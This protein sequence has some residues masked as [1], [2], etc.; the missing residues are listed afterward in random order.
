MPR[1]GG[2]SD[3]TFRPSLLRRG[4]VISSNVGEAESRK[5]QGGFGG[6]SVTILP[7]LVTSKPLP[8][9]QV[10]CEPR[11]VATNF[12]QG[13]AQGPP[14]SVLDLAT[15]CCTCHQHWLLSTVKCTNNR[16]ANGVPTA[17]LEC[18][19]TLTQVH[20]SETYL[21]VSESY[22]QYNQTSYQDEFFYYFLQLYRWLDH[23]P[24]LQL[25]ALPML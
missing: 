12:R 15:G 3:A 8:L 19:W 21:H 6:E 2:S 24:L 18:G 20:A 10:Q 9:P 22:Q 23:Q 16:S 4:C 17:E 13:L 25:A 11:Q 5:Y 7:C 14:F 1:T